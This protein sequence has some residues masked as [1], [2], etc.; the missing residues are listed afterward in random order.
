MGAQVSKEVKPKKGRQGS[1]GSGVSSLDISHTLNGAGRQHGSERRS[2]SFDQ[3]FRDRAP[4]EEK[5]FSVRTCGFQLKGNK[6]LSVKFSHRQTQFDWR[7]DTDYKPKRASVLPSLRVGENLEDHTNQIVAYKQ[8]TTTEPAMASAPVEHQEAAAH[9]EAGAV[10]SA[11]DWS[12][13]LMYSTSIPSMYQQNKGNGTKTLYISNKVIQLMIHRQDCT[14]KQQ[15]LLDT[16]DFEGQLLITSIC[17]AEDNS[18]SDAR[19]L[20]SWPFNKYVRNTNRLSS[21]R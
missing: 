9:E 3:G 18:S 14:W 2:S 4:L 19:E 5:M 7:I 6:N 1:K 12:K 20:L 16:S 8:P 21:L 11:V 13:P 17:P 15:V 10:Y